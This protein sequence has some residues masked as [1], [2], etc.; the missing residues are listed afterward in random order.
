MAIRAP[1]LVNVGHVDH[2]KTTLLDRVRGTAVAKGEPGLIT[3]HVG[4]SFIPAE[5]VR[6]T[7]GPLLEKLKLELTVPGFLWIDTPG[8]AAFTT[9][10]KR[11]GAIADLA[12]LVVDLHQGFQQQTDESLRFLKQFKTPFVVAGT[13]VDKVNGW[14]PVKLPPPEGGEDWSGACFADTWKEQSE[15]AQAECEEKVYKLV[16]QLSARGFVSERFDRVTDYG[17]Q[18]AIVPVSGVTGEGVAD[19]LMV[20]AGIAQRFLRKGL[21]LQPGPGKATVLE[22]KEQK[23]MGMTADLIVYDGEVRKGDVLVIGGTVRGEKVLKTRVKALLRPS[24]LR[25][26]R[27][28]RAFEPVDSVTAAAGV[29]V[30][31]PGL[32]RAMAGAPVRAV[33]TE[34]EAAAA[35]A[36]VLAEVEEVE[37]T[38]SAD[39]I[40]LKADTLGSLEALVKSFQEIGVPVRAARV[41]SLSRSELLELRALPEPVVMAFNLKPD[42]E[43][44]QLAKDNRIAL[45]ESDI[46]YRLLEGYQAWVADRHKRTEE[47]ALEALP[48]PA[49]VRV[50]R[51][52]VFRQRKPAVFG[53]EVEAGLLKAGSRLTNGKEIV[54]TVKEIQQE[55]E[56]KAEAERGERVAISLPEATVGKDVHEG[57]ELFVFLTDAEKAGLE[58]LKHKLTAEERELLG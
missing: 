36:E 46:I 45:F 58:K 28:E 56:N 42:A 55:E 4:A 23:G 32:E 22:V 41:G 3:Q 47:R 14:R 50:L 57:Q 49:K 10:R 5:V 13:K 30:A 15:R 6:K 12:V 34:K 39:G 48:R 52:F 11:G 53:V 25:E 17:K 54:G 35:E 24:P 21:E 37:F 40:L 26:L 20:I 43:L 7:C 27:T 1:I 51:G 31:G 9:L 19:L 2:G 18:V 29:K 16:G 38:T 8:H 44:Q 33:R